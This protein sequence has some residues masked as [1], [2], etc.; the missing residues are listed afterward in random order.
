M[1]KNLPIKMNKNLPYYIFG[2]IAVG[3][4]F[5]D[6]KDDGYNLK[7][8]GISMVAGGVGGYILS[9]NHNKNKI[10]F[11]LLGVAASFGTVWLFDGENGRLVKNNILPYRKE[12]LRKKSNS[13]EPVQKMPIYNSREQMLE[14][15]KKFFGESYELAKSNYFDKMSDSELNTWATCVDIAKQRSEKNLPKITP[16]SNPEC[17]ALSDKFGMDIFGS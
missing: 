14:E 3:N 6:F 13:S 15:G 2:G 9:Q 7:R 11:T 1:N 17:F 5:V 4:Y 16:E 10:L 12:L 8:L